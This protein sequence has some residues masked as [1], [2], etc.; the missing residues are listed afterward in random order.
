MSSNEWAS[1][2]L[3]NDTMM[4]ALWPRLAAPPPP[5]WGDKRTARWQLLV[6]KNAA[7]FGL[8]PE[9]VATVLAL[10]SD[11]TLLPDGTSGEIGLMQIM[12]LEGRP[13]IEIL[14]NPDA[15]IREGCRILKGALVAFD[16]NLAW[17]L[18]AY[19]RGVEGAEEVG[20]S[21][22]EAQAY[23]KRFATVWVELWG[24]DVPQDV[25]DALTP[26]PPEPAINYRW[27]SEQATREIEDALA[28]LTTAHR[29]LVQHVTPY[30]QQ[31]EGVDK[32]KE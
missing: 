10:E 17:A 6:E 24:S 5:L 8:I 31:A 4:R 13:R 21:H 25:R 32:S 18:V 22:P 19:N 11:G 2:N 12:P 27:E 23:L 7:P 30:L 16:G 14:R 20:L 26:K 29:R 9:D 15:N 28:L 1:F 3:R